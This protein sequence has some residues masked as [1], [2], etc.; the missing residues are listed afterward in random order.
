MAVVLG[1][2]KTVSL[3][4]LVT[5]VVATTMAATVFLICGR[6]S[7]STQITDYVRITNIHT[8]PNMFN[9]MPNHPGL[10]LSSPLGSSGLALGQCDPQNRTSALQRFKAAQN[11]YNALRDD[12][13]T[14]VT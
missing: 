14:Y 13:F 10:P 7:L 5:I 12:K 4:R 1:G 6:A 2:L 8:L 11:K 3:R 9:T